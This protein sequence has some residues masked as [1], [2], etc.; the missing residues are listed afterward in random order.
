MAM[1]TTL[2]RLARTAAQF[3]VDLSGALNVQHNEIGKISN[4]LAHAAPVWTARG[5][6]HAPGG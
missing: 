1:T 6:P 2:A 4:L 3:I 5:W